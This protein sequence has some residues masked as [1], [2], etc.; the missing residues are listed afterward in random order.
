MSEQ[1]RD[2]E[3]LTDM[4]EAM[5][6]IRVYTEGV[7]YE[8]F[9]K[10]TKTQYAVIRNLEVIGEA[11]KKVSS[12]LKSSYPQLPWR[13]MV[14]MRDEVIHHYFGINY[15]IVWNVAT[16]EVPSLLSEIDRILH[17]EPE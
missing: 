17:H 12:S 3:Y 16:Q 6:R 14:R 10:D 13:S 9:L 2:R 7:T 15:D 4:V 5:R 8:Q 1:R 11:A